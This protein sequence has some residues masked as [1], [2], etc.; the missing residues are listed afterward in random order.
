MKKKIIFIVL[1]VILIIVLVVISMKKNDISRFTTR[2]IFISYRGD[3]LS[4]P[5][6]ESD[7]EVYSD[8]NIW[9]RSVEKGKV[10]RSISDEELET[11][12]E[13]LIE[14]DYMSLGD[15]YNLYGT[16]NFEEITINIDGNKK[17]IKLN[18]V[19]SRDD[20]KNAPEKLKGFL[21][22]FKQIVYEE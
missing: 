8:G 6:G 10:K 3:T 1:I 4:F 14:I 19:I 11:L 2:E 16:G 20:A 18:Y 5:Y 17:K 7:F 13:K 15:E 21:K 22:L 9:I 12:K